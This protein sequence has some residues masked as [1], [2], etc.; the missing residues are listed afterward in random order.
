MLPSLALPRLSH[1]CPNP[2]SA[3]LG[4][5]NLNS[6]CPLF[7]IFHFFC[8]L[9]VGLFCLFVCL[10]PIIVSR[11]VAERH[12]HGHDGGQ[13][14]L[15]VVECSKRFRAKK[16][17]TLQG[18]PQSLARLSGVHCFLWRALAGSP[19]LLVPKGFRRLIMMMGIPSRIQVQ[20]RVFTIRVRH[21]ALPGSVASI[22]FSGEPWP[23]PPSF[24]FG[25]ASGD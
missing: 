19:E 13:P 23:A 25:R 22:A 14:V 16:G 10:L 1:P 24:L 20:R 2:D 7:F 15:R 18:P 11:M 17:V 21:R 9:L 4:F 3:L 8:F 12:H 6:H 5:S